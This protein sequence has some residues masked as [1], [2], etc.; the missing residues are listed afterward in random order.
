[1]YLPTKNTY[2]NKYLITGISGPGIEQLYLPDVP[3][4]SLI[5]FEKEQKFVRPE[6]PE[7]LKKAVKEMLFHRNERTRQGGELVSPD[8]VHPKF[9][10]EIN[11]WEEREF[12]RSSNGIWFWNN[13]VPTYISPFYYWYLS[14]WRPYFGFPSYRETDKELTYWLKY[15]EEDPN[16]YGGAFNTIRRYGKSVLMGGWSV[17]RTTRSFNHFCGM[18]GETDDKIKKFY[19]KFIKKPF[20]KLPWYYQPTYN[21]ATQQTNQIEFDIPP[22]RNK[23]NVIMDEIESLESIIEYRESSEGAYDG[24]I[25]NTYLMEEPGKTKKVSVYNEEGDGRWDVVVPCLNDGL[26]IIGKALLGTTVENLNMRDKGGQAYKNLFYD[27]DFNQ[28]QEDGRTKSGLYT[29]FIPGDCAL[30]G[31][32]DE[33]GH[34]KREEARQALLKRRKSFKNNANRLAGHIR[35]YPLT[36]KEIFYINPTGCEF[37]AAVLQDRRD[38]IDM[39]P[40]SMVERFDLKWQNNVRFSKVVLRPNPT[41]GWFKASWIPRDPETECNLVQEKMTT[42]QREF[43]PLND[44][45]FAIGMDPIDHGVVVEGR[46]LNADEVNSGRRSRPVLFIKT[47][48]D[49]SL[50]GFLSQEELELRAQPG[51]MVNDKWVLDDNGR[52]YDYKSNRYF[53]MMDTRPGDPNVLYE[54]ALMLCWYFGC[55]LHI[56]NQ[57]PGTIRYFY[58]HG[59]GDFILNKYVPLEASMRVRSAIDDGTAASTTIIQ[60]Y[61]GELSTYI[62]YFGHTI[63][64]R[65]LIEDLLLFNPRKTT[66][67]DYSVAAGFCELACKIK[68]KTQ[69]KPL[70]DLEE[71]MLQYDRWGR[72]VN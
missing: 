10:Y 40:V 11:D 35:K 59:C 72:I 32:W 18:Q 22:K 23:K 52:K 12:E 31:F 63:P 13:G 21:T 45:R 2:S 7:H 42:G 37:N 26:E 3:T 57:K 38:E 36:V 49:S 48:Y 34:P 28:K 51:K 29:A 16:C 44:K 39:S 43:A 56:E 5:L 24:D 47:K 50:D 54:R 65:E 20:Y 62:E 8:W 61:T 27:S 46:S 33:W 53:G 71:V 70:F 6:L 41:N 66:E 14:G 19:N 64:F 69:P 25:L 4:D 30:K 67:Y 60:E 1:M 17:N 55:S 58:E 9:Q 15:I 68:P